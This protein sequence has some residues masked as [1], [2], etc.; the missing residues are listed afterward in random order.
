MKYLINLFKTINSNVGDSTLVY[1]GDDIREYESKVEQLQAFFRDS[2]TLIRTTQYI[3]GDGTIT[4][5][6]I[7]YSL[8]K[9]NKQ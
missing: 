8:I 3:K 9:E 6:Y 4:Q 1:I 2:G 5:A 7:E